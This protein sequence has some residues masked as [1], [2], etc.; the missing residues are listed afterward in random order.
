MPGLSRESNHRLAQ[1]TQYARQ[2]ASSPAVIGARDRQHLDDVGL[3][4]CDIILINQV[5]G[6][7]GFQARVVAVLQAYFGH[8]LRRIPGLDVQQYAQA[9]IFNN[10]DAQWHMAAFPIDVIPPREASPAALTKTGASRIY[11]R[12]RRCWHIHRR[13][14]L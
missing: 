12:S 6:F 3:T 8:P 10:A 7:V 1:I 5:I 4:T 13:Y 9:A 14:W 2:L 11:K